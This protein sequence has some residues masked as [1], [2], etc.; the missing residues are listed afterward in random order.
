MAKACVDAAA[1]AAARNPRFGSTTLLNEMI[2]PAK[3][4]G[5][6][7]VAR[8]VHNKLNYDES[9]RMQHATKMQSA[10]PPPPKHFLSM[11]K[12][13]DP[14]LQSAKLKPPPKKF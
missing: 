7:R 14:T 1:T 3:M 13:F 10:K 4:P 5:S 2:P 12:P 6:T 9:A 11:K 8:T